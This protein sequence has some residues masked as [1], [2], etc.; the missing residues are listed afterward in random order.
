MMFETRGQIRWTVIGTLLAIVSWS[1]MVYV[2]GLVHEWMF[3]LGIVM[4]AAAAIKFG[5]YVTRETIANYVDLK[6]AVIRTPA[7]E[8]AEQLR[9]IPPEGLRIVETVTKSQ[10]D[11]VP[12]DD[13]PQYFVRGTGVTLG[14]VDEFLDQSNAV[15]LC[16]IRTYNDGSWQRTAASELTDYF[17]KRGWAIPARVDAANE[18]AR[19]IGG[20]TPINVRIQFGMIEQEEATPS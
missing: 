4:M 16:P 20:M 17:V 13:G 19:W 2:D 11:I 6:A 9:G 15:Y 14:F 8:L 12:G 10:L 18:P 1:S 5:E 7:S 3:Y